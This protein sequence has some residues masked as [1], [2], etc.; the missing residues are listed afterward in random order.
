MQLS[1]LTE[2]FDDDACL[3]DFQKAVNFLQEL[4]LKLAEGQESAELRDSL[5]MCLLHLQKYYKVQFAHV[6]GLGSLL[7]L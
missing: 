6:S 3:T 7:N 4:L 2:R 1:T 5:N